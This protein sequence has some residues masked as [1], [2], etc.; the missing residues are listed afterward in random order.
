MGQAML[1]GVY[2]SQSGRRGDDK[3]F[4]PGALMHRL[5]IMKS[6]EAPITHQW[7]DST[8]IAF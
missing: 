8:Q 7:V 3:A 4:G 2:D 6:P 5:P 1:K